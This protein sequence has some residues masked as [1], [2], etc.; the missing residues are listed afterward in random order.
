M[1]ITLAFAAMIASAETDPYYGWFHP[2]RDGTAGMNDEINHEFE[3]GL[4][5]VNLVPPDSCLAAARGTVSRLSA[6]A[7]WFW[8]GSTRFWPVDRSPKTRREYNDQFRLESTY[9]WT[10]LLPFGSFV[11]LDPTVR[12]GD[13]LFGTDKIG[14]FFTNGLRYYERFLKAR[15]AGASEDGAERAAIATG[16]EEENTNLGV[17]VS[18]IFSYADLESNWRGLEFFRDLCEGDHPALVVAKS[19]KWIL[20]RPFHIE[21][22]V[23]PCWDEGFYPSWFAPQSAKNVQRAIASSCPRWT[24]LKEIGV[25]RARYEELGCSSKGVAVLKELG[26]KGKAPD[27]WPFSIDKICGPTARPTPSDGD[28]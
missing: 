25:R 28:R 14:H 1:V 2:P 18:G 9:R 20:T 7:A 8:A 11:P 24:S 22:W 15:K 12:V 21:R 17:S 4:H 6:T 16:V 23:D 27:S 26:A 3:L 19:G 10:A 13:I 5:D